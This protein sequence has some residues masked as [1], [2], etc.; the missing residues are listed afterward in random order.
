MLKKYPRSLIRSE[1]KRIGYSSDPFFDMFEDEL[2]FSKIT[3]NVSPLRR[4]IEELRSRKN[5]NLPS[6]NTD[7]ILSPTDLLTQKLQ[8]GEITKYCK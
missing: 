6:L 1:V 7:K 5:K 2:P 3:K 4:R 8:S